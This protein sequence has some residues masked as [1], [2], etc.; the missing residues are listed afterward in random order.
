MDILERILTVIQTE[1]GPDIFTE[2][3]RE[4]F[5]RQFRF[6]YGASE[7]YVASLRAMEVAEKHQ[8][9][10]RLIRSRLTNSE[11]AERVGYASQSAFAAAMLREF[12]AAPSALRRT[13]K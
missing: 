13:T 7:H 3:K 5:E 2:A 1:L 11:I 12:G 6:E 4:L 9:V 10:R 8:E